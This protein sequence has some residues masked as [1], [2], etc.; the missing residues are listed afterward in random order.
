MGGQFSKYR[1]SLL[2]ACARIEQMSFS[3]IFDH[4][5]ASCRHIPYLQPEILYCL[6]DI[7]LESSILE[8]R[9]LLRGG[10]WQEVSYNIHYKSE[11]RGFHSP[12]SA[13]RFERELE[14]LR[15]EINSASSTPTSANQPSQSSPTSLK[16]S[17]EQ[18]DDT[19]SV[20][21]TGNSQQTHLNTLANA[22]L[23]PA[24]GLS[25]SPLALGPTDINGD[26]DKK[27]S[28]TQF[29]DLD[30]GAPVSTDESRKDR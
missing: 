8:W 24:P 11:P 18:P 7:A 13:S 21:S 30:L 15:K 9:E 6:L 26:S 27:D 20:P 3:S 4:L 2:L 29:D 28:K 1:R 17:G 19:G 22:G 23:R 5:H 14:K 16:N 12:Y 25:N 10:L